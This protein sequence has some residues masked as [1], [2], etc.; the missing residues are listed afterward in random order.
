MKR[1]FLT[2]EE[3]EKKKKFELF[4]S[5]LEGVADDLYDKLADTIV[6]LSPEEKADEM[7]K[8]ARVMIDQHKK[9]K[10]ANKIGAVKLPDGRTKNWA[11]ISVVTKDLL[12]FSDVLDL[13][14]ELFQGASRHTAYLQ[15]TIEE[16]RRTN[17]ASEVEDTEFMLFYSEDRATANLF[18]R[19]HDAYGVESKLVKQKKRALWCITS[20]GQDYFDEY[21]AESY[22]IYAVRKKYKPDHDDFYCILVDRD[23]GTIDRYWD[24]LDEPHDSVSDINPLKVLETLVSEEKDGYSLVGENWLYSGEE[25]SVM[26]VPP[27]VETLSQ[28]T[29]KGVKNMREVVMYNSEVSIQGNMFSDCVFLERVTLPVGATSI[30]CGAFFFYS[31]FEGTYK[32]FRY[33]RDW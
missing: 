8:Y 1:R 14:A 3:V 17:I 18:G 26:V 33:N 10:S 21:R 24:Q 23:L 29:F 30:E 25:T 32:H 22:F 27:F 9:Q 12:S 20:P 31:S 19:N 28:F 16:V 11:D 5:L 4:V 2:R 13:E 6:A 15:K 7:K